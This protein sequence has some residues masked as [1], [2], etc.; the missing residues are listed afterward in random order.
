MHIRSLDGLRGVAILLVV[1]YHYLP[2]Y[3]R[4]PISA[5]ASLGWS[6][7]DLFFVLSGFL[8][9]GILYDTRTASGRFSAFYARRALRL[10][11]LYSLAIAV[12]LVGTHFLRGYRTWSDIPL[13]LYCANITIVLPHP[14]GTF[15][16]YF[17]CRHFWSLALE[18]QFYSIWPFVVFFV[19]RRGSLMK[20]CLGGIAAALALRITLAILGVSM[21]VVN[22][23]L[24]TRMD[25]LLIGALLALGVR[26]PNPER[27][28]DRRTLLRIMLAAAVALAAVLGIAKTL[29]WTSIPM[30]T[31]GY[32]ILAVIYASML[33]LALIPGSAT[34]RIGSNAVLRFFG[35]YSYG[36]YVW[37][38]LFIP[39]CSKWSAWFR[40]HIHFRLAADAVCTM[41]LLAVFTGMAVSSYWLFEVHFLRLKSKYTVN[42]KTLKSVPAA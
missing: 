8:I 14:P 39:V 20:I 7:V 24:P 13:F 18:E 33:A 9:T 19:P 25:S 40:A 5:I 2:R 16:P 32:T 10:L 6:G 29:F 37:H 36:L 27:W 41:T 21:S 1:F 23:Q 30:S 15:L 31:A 38:Y 3:N 4:N 34:N 11:P 28:L 35:K 12:I 26:G 17:D 22:T 42:S